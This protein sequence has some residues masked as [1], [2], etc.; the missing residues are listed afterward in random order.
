MNRRLIHLAFLFAV[1]WMAP[2]LRLCAQQTVQS[3]QVLG[4]IHN[5]AGGILSGVSVHL[6]QEGRSAIEASTNADGAFI[7]SALSAGDYTITL[8][9][10]GFRDRIDSIKL[11]AAEIKHCD[12]VLTAAS[13][14]TFSASVQLDDRPNF[15]VAGVTDTA[16][17][18]GH[19]SETRMRTGEVLA[20]KTAALQPNA[21]TRNSSPRTDETG[22]NAAALE[23]SLRASLLQSPQSYDANHH[24]GEFYFRS[25]NYSQ[26][27]PLLQAAFQL[28]PYDHAN[29]FTLALALNAAGDF[30][31][32]REQVK[33]MLANEK[34]VPGP[35]ESNLRRL[36]GDLNEKLDDPLAA[37]REYERAAALDASEQ[38][39]FAWGA[40][41]LLHHAAAPAIEVFGTGAR[42]HPDSARLLAGLGASLYISGSV[43][44]AAE[45]LC[46]ASDLE[47][48]N[49]Q[50]YLFLGKMQEATSTP[51]PCAEAKLARFVKDEPANALAN[52]YYALALWKRDR[53]VPSSETL[54]R[55][56][57]LLKKATAIDSKLDSAYL[58]L[59][60][61]YLARGDFEAAIKVYQNA[62]TANPAS[63]QAHYR[64]G[65]TYKR[66]GDEE[67]SKA[68]FVQYKELEKKE[69]DQ[70]EQERR[71]LRQF[72][73]V[74]KGAP[75]TASR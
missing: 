53:G 13:P 55:A 26:A 30:A 38:N 39:Y 50:P 75:D 48:A 22:V 11:G 16:G 45:R 3:A 29:S 21:S 23:N 34:S 41:L 73:F 6:R 32:A 19:G 5:S 31:Q 2:G 74:F 9:K 54:D 17:S 40:E 47:P 56:E 71:E 58:Q 46:G 65:L 7:F 35:D 33:R 4:V 67:K 57:T 20:R 60:N 72:L 12:L 52:Y 43:E 62:I 51:L 42:L 59:G 61:L 68:E 10:A 64:L 66:L 63:S 28:N 15:T 24:L 27:I 25:G 36:L 69:A 8:Q 37:E 70:V 44:E 49:P 1:L 18:G 14:A